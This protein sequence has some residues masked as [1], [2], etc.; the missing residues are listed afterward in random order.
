MVQVMLSKTEGMWPEGRLRFRRAFAQRDSQGNSFMDSIDECRTE[1]AS[2]SKQIIE[3]IETYIREGG[4][5][6]KDWYIG[7]TD[8]PIEPV[9][10]A[11]LLN[12]V[13]NHRFTYIETISSRVAK[14]VADYFINLCGADGHFSTKEIS[15]A[16]KSLYVYKKAAHLVG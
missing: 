4:G 9:D 12:K 16:C 1:L 8:N 11:L 14:T 15:R 5:E 10:E 13:Q 3:Q 7:M 2:N 6:Y